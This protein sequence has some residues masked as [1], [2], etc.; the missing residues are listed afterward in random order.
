MKATAAHVGTSS[1]NTLVAL[2]R[3]QS[4]PLDFGTFVYR[5]KTELPRLVRVRLRKSR[6]ATHQKVGMIGSDFFGNRVTGVFHL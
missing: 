1:A 2:Q 3:F 5:H 6:H 4:L